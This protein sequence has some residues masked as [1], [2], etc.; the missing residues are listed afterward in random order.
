MIS[1]V[2]IPVEEYGPEACLEAVRHR[3]GCCDNVRIVRMLSRILDMR[4]P[5][6]FYYTLT[7]VAETSDDAVCKGCFPVYVEPPVPDRKKV[8]ADRKP[9]VVGFG[10]AGMF[11]ALEL[12]EHGL[13]PVIVER[14]KTIEERTLDVER[15]IRERRLNPES[16][17]Q[18]G[19]GGAG[20]YS[21]G[22]LFSRRNRNSGYAG[23]VLDTFIRFGAPPEIAYMG[24]PHLGTDVLCRIVR[25]I[26]NHILQKG[27]EIHYSS[28]MTDMVISGGR[29]QGVCTSKGETLEAD[30]VYL[31][32]GHSARDTFF[33]LHEKGVAMEPRPVRV[34]VR[35][36]HPADTVNLMRY[37]SKYYRHKNLGAA[38]YSLNHTDRAIKRGV[39]T[40]CM[41]PGGEVVNASS[42]PGGLVL[43]GM[44]YAARSSV[45]SN[46]ALVVTC[47]VED[48]PGKDCLAGFRFQE[49]IEAKALKAGG[50]AWRAPAQNLMTF[51]GE[52]RGCFFPETSYKM[53]IQAADMHDIFPDF[54]LDCLHAAFQKWR[55][56]VPLFVSEEALLMAA[57]TR[58]S[59][60]VRIL[61]NE[62]YESL[63]VKGL[64]PIGEGA[65]YTG[66]ITS[67]AI[68]AIKAV[69]RRIAAHFV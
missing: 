30:M 48:Y 59:S 8:D 3:L 35:I 47:H 52:K 6:Q 41:C 7:M 4:D 22:K 55:R 21:D 32:M 36:E 38:T 46:A 5:E 57:E 68:D 11:A 51:L 45:F 14:G 31:A 62:E 40:F 28:K 39:Y 54:I 10:P 63:N 43:N 53:G 27:G 61:R 50:G 17:I 18:F 67:S 23:R 19:E 56:E 29:V 20:S 42:H 1:N 2:K 15:F 64:F 34:G 37:G 60:P 16:N 44:S 49:G 58:T 69:E 65:G 26:R 33:L 66:G 25:N 12:L 13:K 24:K 9:I